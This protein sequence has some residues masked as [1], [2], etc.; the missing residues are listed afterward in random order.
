MAP[1]RLL[2][3]E[4]MVT[5]IIIVHIGSIPKHFTQTTRATEEEEE[6][7]EGMV[8]VG[9]DNGQIVGLLFFL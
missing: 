5:M 6:E 3:V 1:P 7:E 4:S 8:V 9:M 2:R